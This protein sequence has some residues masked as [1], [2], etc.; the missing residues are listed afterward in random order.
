[1]QGIKAIKTRGYRTIFG[2]KKKTKNA[3]DDQDFFENYQKLS[4]YNSN[5]VASAPEWDSTK[6]LLPDLTGKHVID[7]G[8]GFGLFSEYAMTKG[9]KSVYALDLSENMIAKAKK[10]TVQ[11]LYHI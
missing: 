11:S 9:A 8:C 3:Y 5:D 1:M 10:R 6:A 4:R 2:V 7:L